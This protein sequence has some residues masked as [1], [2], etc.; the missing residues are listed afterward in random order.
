M[1]Y[2]HISVAQIPAPGLDPDGW[3]AFLLN[4]LVKSGYLR[5]S[6]HLY[7]INTVSPFWKAFPPNL[8]L[9]FA[10]FCEYILDRV[11]MWKSKFLYN[12]I[13]PLGI[14]THVWM[15]VLELIW[16]PF[17]LIVWSDTFWR[18]LIWDVLYIIILSFLSTCDICLL[19]LNM[20]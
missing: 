7:L 4:T 3:D 14:N 20:L 8:M 10:P 18:T 13:S 19:L 6:S 16:L 2:F 15:F 1:R 12:Q 9:L 17:C 5:Y 11:V